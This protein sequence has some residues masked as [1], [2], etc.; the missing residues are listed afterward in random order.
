MYNLSCTQ[1]CKCY[2]TLPKFLLENHRII[3]KSANQQIALWDSRFDKYRCYPAVDRIYQ[4]FPDKNLQRADVIETFRNDPYTGCIAAMMW[5]GI[6]TDRKKNEK[7]KP[8][9]QKLLE[10]DKTMVEVAIAYAEQEIASGNLENVFIQFSRGGQHKLPGVDSSYFTKL[11]FFIE[12]VNGCAPVKP[13]IFDKWTSIAHCALSIQILQQGEQL[14]YNGIGRDKKGKPYLKIPSGKSRAE[15]YVRFVEDLAA[16]AGYLTDTKPYFQ[17]TEAKLE[18][19]VFGKSLKFHSPRNPRTA[20]W[21]IIHNH[22]STTG[23]CSP[24]TETHI[25]IPTFPLRTKSKRSRK[26]K[27]QPLEIYFERGKANSIREFILSLEEI[28]NILLS[29]GSSKLPENA[30]RINQSFWANSGEEFHVQ[31]KAWLHNGYKAYVIEKEG[32]RP[33]QIAFKSHF[34]EYLA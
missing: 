27:Y 31:K 28:N 6:N 11:F 7:D 2:M 20:F 33:I 22:F 29:G 23:T 14:P 1:I 21:A 26:S 3:I 17:V 5:G 13:L 19:F 9:F 24:N 10:Y 32:N 8:S 18:E 30:Y 4:L 12:Q 34:F 25:N 15:L 16:W